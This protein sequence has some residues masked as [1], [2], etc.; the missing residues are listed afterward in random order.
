MSGVGRDSETHSYTKTVSKADNKAEALTQP[1]LE[2]LKRYN[3]SDVFVYADPPYLWATRKKYLYKYE[4]G[5]EAEHIELLQ[6][7]LQ[8]PG[9]VMISG[10]DNEIYNYYLKGWNKAYK[11]TQVEKGIKRTETLWMNYRES[12]M[13]LLDFAFDM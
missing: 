11:E 3:T 12:Q 13:S 1:V 8:H 7:L 4:M 9:P 6:S 10:Y 2:I 5:G